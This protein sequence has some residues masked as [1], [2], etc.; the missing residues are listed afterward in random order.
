MKRTAFLFSFFIV[1][2]L[3]HAQE[4]YNIILENATRTVNSPT[5][6][7]TQA[8]IAQFKRTALLY[9]KR[10]AFEQSDTVS[11]DLLNTQAYYLN[12]F[13]S[14]FFN[15]I[16]KAKD[17][18]DEKRKAKIVLFMQA[19]LEC[20]LFGDTDEETT[21]AFVDDKEGLTPFSLDTDWEKAYLASQELL[22]KNS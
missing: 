11:A 15:E 20:P 13:L 19:S 2:S 6:G 21:L 18:S 3:S 8:Q 12:E 4:V 7:F 1:C 14:S 17:Q 22:K 9:L 5:T 16:L 10:K